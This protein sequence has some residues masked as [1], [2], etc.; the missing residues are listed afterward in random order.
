MSSGENLEKPPP[1]LIIIRPIAIAV[2]ENTPITVSADAAV[3]CL[4]HVMRSANITEKMSSDV[5]GEN[6][7]TSAPMAMPVN[8]P[9]PR[10]SEKNAMR[11]ETTI[12]ESSPKRGVMR[13]VARSAFFMNVYSIDAN[14]SSVS[15]AS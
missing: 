3:R 10:E 5:S 6:I 15:I 13:I 8:A 9:C 4:I 12:V 7:P 1:W 14:G 11:L 2:E